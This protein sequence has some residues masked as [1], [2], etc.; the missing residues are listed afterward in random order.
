[1]GSDKDTPLVLAVAELPGPPSGTSGPPGSFGF[2]GSCGLPGSLGRPGI[3]GGSA[4][5]FEYGFDSPGET[6]GAPSGSFGVEGGFLGRISA[7]S[8]RS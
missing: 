6:G 5:E 2:S 4:S 1:V 3:V 8:E 7:F